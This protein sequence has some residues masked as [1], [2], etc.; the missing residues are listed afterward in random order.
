M[1][2]KFRFVFL[3]CF[4][5]FIFCEKCLYA[6]LSDVVVVL[7]TSGSLL[8]Y[9]DEINGK[10]LKEIFTDYVRKNDVFHLISFDTSVKLEISQIVDSE[11][12][13]S[14]IICKF[15][16][17][18]PLVKDSNMM[19][20]LD[21]LEDYLQ[22]LPRLHNKK[23]IFISDGLFIPSGGNGDYT[24]KEL[25][26]KL[27]DFS[28]YLLKTGKIQ[29]YYIKLPLSSNQI[30]LDLKNDL[31]TF[32]NSSIE[33]A[34]I[35]AY[36]LVFNLPLSLSEYL[37]FNE[38]EWP[39]FRGRGLQSSLD[40]PN[41]STDSFESI[42]TEEKKETEE[43]QDIKKIADVISDEMT[44][45]KHIVEFDANLDKHDSTPDVDL[46]ME[47]N[48]GNFNSSMLFRTSYI[49]LIFLILF[50]LLILI[51][52]KKRSKGKTDEDSSS[53]NKNVLNSKINISSMANENVEKLQDENITTKSEVFFSSVEEYLSTN[54]KNYEHCNFRNEELNEKIVP[55]QKSTLSEVIPKEFQKEEKILLN[56]KT[57]EN[58]L[59]TKY[60]PS[61]FTLSPDTKKAF[62]KGSAIEN[63]VS[64]LNS[65]YID[66]GDVF[67]K[68]K[69]SLYTKKYV[70]SIDLEKN[71]YLEIFV[72]NQRR[73]IGMRNIH[74]LTP[75][76]TFY[77]GGERSDDF[78]IFLVPIPRHLASICY[79]GKEIVFTILK[80][81]YFPYEKEIE[82]K[83]PIDRFFVLNSDKNY[84]IQFMFRLYEKEGIST[85]SNNVVFK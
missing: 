75:N 34:E 2:K 3:F 1:F 12:D 38:I 61:F 31:S 78:L 57:V 43:I 55:K 14:R 10:I 49:F 66:N 25:E 64:L 51:F 5:S 32:V 46:V 40:F 70:K 81:K 20:T 84:S 44:D 22:S 62:A 15:L 65:S 48:Y 54:E 27:N 80:P 41:T 85:S 83:N 11:E 8:T 72:L 36:P 82:I 13:F 29:T 47:E 23:V 4:F 16:L 67:Y 45:I 39:I 37:C 73:S 7:D 63:M 50:A 24:K 58:R 74:P 68:F 30:V 33:M 71:N 42:N 56:V 59:I 35:E 69:N 79:D 60:S 17:A 77:L 18:Y 21:F 52:N 9:Y 28:A 26:K 19:I 53:N 76:K 6:E